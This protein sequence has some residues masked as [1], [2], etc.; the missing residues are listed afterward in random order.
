MK[1]K[2]VIKTDR[3]LS[4]KIGD[5]RTPVSW[6]MGSKADSTLT[7]MSSPLEAVRSLRL[8]LILASTLCNIE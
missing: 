7:S 2:F 4:C 8:F 5:V 6:M 3:F 1:L